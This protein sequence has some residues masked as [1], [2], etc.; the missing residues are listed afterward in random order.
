MP[1][2]KHSMFMQLRLDFPLA[3]HSSATLDNKQDLLLLLT[4]GIA[5]SKGL[6]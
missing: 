2:K 4:M 1:A 3:S 6:L 5:L